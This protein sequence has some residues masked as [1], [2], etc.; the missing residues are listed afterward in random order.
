MHKKLSSATAVYGRLGPKVLGHIIMEATAETTVLLPYYPGPPLNIKTIFPGLGI[1][2]L[3]IRRSWDHLIFNMGIPILVRRH[4]YI[5]TAPWFGLASNLPPPLT[6]P[7]PNNF[8][9]IGWLSKA[10]HISLRIELWAHNLFVKR[11]PRP[12]LWQV[13]SYVLTPLWQCDMQTKCS[14]IS[15]LW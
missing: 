5:E 3:K 11:V 8:D 13:P 7:D 15:F 12:R 10:T 14:Q 6:H 1:P 4:L 2:M 9:L